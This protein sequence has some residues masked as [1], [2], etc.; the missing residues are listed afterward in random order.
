VTSL[1]SI[2]VFLVLTYIHFWRHFNKLDYLKTELHNSE[3]EIEFGD[4][5]DSKYNKQNYA[6]V[7]SFNEYFDTKV[8]DK[9]IAKSSLNG[10]FLNKIVTSKGI[11]EL[12]KNISKDSNLEIMKNGINLDRKQGKKNKYR[13]GSIYEYSPKFLL[14]SLSKF[15][16][17]NRA[18]LNTLDYL[19]FLINFWDQLD[20]KYAQ[21]VI[22]IPLFGSGITR[23]ENNIYSD[24]ELLKIILWS[25]AIRRIKFS[26]PGKL[27]I[28]IGK[29]LKN[30]IN[31]FEIK[32]I[33]KNGIS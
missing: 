13:L 16:D 28:V 23:I 31:L 25:F 12:N 30:K 15:D 29:N 20:S 27:K 33:I 8:D 26:Y 17:N 5:F 32:E 3:I 14:T 11:K 18:V 22:I 10:Q 4:I 24:Q 19:N 21:K 9:I 2:L 1:I 7:F 6:R